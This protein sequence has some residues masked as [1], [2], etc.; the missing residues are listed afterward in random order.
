MENFFLKKDENK[1]AKIDCEIKNILEKV[2]K[3]I[4][5]YNINSN[6]VHWFRLK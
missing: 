5:N 1:P 2:P 3:Q 4:P 6:L